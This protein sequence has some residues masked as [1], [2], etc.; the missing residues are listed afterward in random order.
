MAGVKISAM[1]RARAQVGQ[2][3]EVSVQGG[4]TTGKLCLFTAPAGK[5][6]AVVAAGGRWSTATSVSGGTVS[7]E[8]VPSGTATGSGT[9]IATAE[10]AA[11]GTANT[12]NY[13][14]L[15]DTEGSSG[16]NII[17]P[18]ESL[19]TIN[20]G[21]SGTLTALAGLHVFAIIRELPPL[22]GA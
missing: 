1:G 5:R 17:E 16:K 15:D 10:L 19:Y 14:T 9:N 20:T 22:K 11:D 13:L 18:G 3:F 21:N 2:E 8:R 6:F 12:L 4:G 7:L